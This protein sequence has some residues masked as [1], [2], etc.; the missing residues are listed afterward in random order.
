[1]MLLFLGI[2]ERTS[3]DMETSKDAEKIIKDVQVKM[4]AQ[5]NPS[6]SLV[7]ADSTTSY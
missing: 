6:P 3:E 7:R 1:M 5:S 4:E 2:M